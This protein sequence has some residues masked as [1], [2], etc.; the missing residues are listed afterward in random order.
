MSSDFNKKIFLRSEKL[1]NLYIAI[2][3]IGAAGFLIML[4]IGG[5][6]GVLLIPTVLGIIMPA[7]KNKPLLSRLYP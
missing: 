1:N 2:V 5:P 3:V 6:G 4:M 7:T